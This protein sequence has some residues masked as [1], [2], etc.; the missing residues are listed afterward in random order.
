MTPIE[1][2]TR[3]LEDLRGETDAKRRDQIIGQALWDAK[4]A[5]KRQVREAVTNAQDLAYDDDEMGSVCDSCGKPFREHL[6]LLGTCQRLQV[7]LGVLERLEELGKDSEQASNE[8]AARCEALENA[9]A[10]ATEIADLHHFQPMKGF[11]PLELEGD[12]PYVTTENTIVWPMDRCYWYFAEHPDLAQWLRERDEKEFR[13][14]KSL[15]KEEVRIELQEAGIDPDGLAK[16]TME[17][18]E[19]VRKLG[20]VS[21]PSCNREFKNFKALTMHLSQSPG[22][23]AHMVNLRD[24]KEKK[25][26]GN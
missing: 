12:E 18:L 23:T 5:E 6:G 25:N 20:W 14:I 26:A 15:S 3:A 19:E 11:I 1:I 10:F 16:K 8:L 9:L 21:C 2:L 7:A 22:C 4:D 17:R 13:R 24:E